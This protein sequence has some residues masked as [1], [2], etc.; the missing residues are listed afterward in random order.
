MEANV[1]LYLKMNFR[2]NTKIKVTCAVPWRHAAMLTC[3]SLGVA[4]RGDQIIVEGENFTNAEVLNLSKGLLQF[5]GNDGTVRSVHLGSIDLLIT[6]RGGLFDDF[7]EAERFLDAGEPKKAALRYKR[8]LQLSGGY[9]SDLI[10]ARL[11]IAHDR[12]MEVNKAV[13]YLIRVTRGKWAGPVAGAQLIPMNL[14]NKRTGSLARA[15]RELDGALATHPQQAQA[16]IFEVTRYELLRRM[17]DALAPAAAMRLAAKQIPVAIRTDRV[18]DILVSAMRTAVAGNVSPE[19]MAGIDRAIG[20]CPPKHLPDFLL[21]KGQALLRGAVDREDL[22]R[23]SWP[24]LRVAIH[25]HNDPRA[26]QGL[27]GAA[28]VLERLEDTPGTRRL[29][30][31]CITSA[32][33]KAAVVDEARRMLD[34]FGA[35]EKSND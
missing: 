5:R 1:G 13:R 30:N 8:A 22:M 20:E 29:L 21:L 3:L 18:Y 26:A 9:W 25:M 31:E 6:N 14:G 27:L 7:N 32:N 10:A 15:V 19:V 2:I 28:K 11:V 35:G 4:A 16:M 24:F 17:H 12:A 33:A 34:E 23:A